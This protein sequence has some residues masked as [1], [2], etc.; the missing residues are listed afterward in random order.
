MKTAIMKVT[1]ARR[2]K[3]LLEEFPDFENYNVLDLG[4]TVHTWTSECPVQPKAVTVVNTFPLQD[5]YLSWMTV[6]QDDATKYD[7]QAVSNYDFVYCNSVIEHV[8]GH[9]KRGDLGLTIERAAPRYWVQTPY[10]YFPIEPH[11]RFPGFQFLP[12]NVRVAI[13][14]K[15][16]LTGYCG[17][18]KPQ[19]VNSV[20]GVELL[21]L[22][23][24]KSYFPGAEVKL[25]FKSII[26]SRKG[27]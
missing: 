9:S 17:E 3:R 7:W 23:E 15:W 14:R 2:W 10:R 1:R 8:G 18:T 20:L 12:T 16:P 19:A 4:G 27:V 21:N 24:M 5:P 11:W 26:A 6:F 13:S 25:D 22:T